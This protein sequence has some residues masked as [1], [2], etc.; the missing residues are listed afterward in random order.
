MQVFPSRT[1]HCVNGRLVLSTGARSKAF[2]VVHLTGALVGAAGNGGKEG[3]WDMRE[4]E[5]GGG[6]SAY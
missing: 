6:E 1:N 5:E 3:K 4:K 2:I